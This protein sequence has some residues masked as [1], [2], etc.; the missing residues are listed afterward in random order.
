MY[1]YFV[2]PEDRRKTNIA[3]GEAQDSGSLI[4]GI[5]SGQ[6]I[7]VGR[8]QVNLKI[9]RSVHVLFVFVL[10]YNFQFLSALSGQLIQGKA[11][12]KRKCASLISMVTI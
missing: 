12:M 4:S 10:L 6:C 8:G 9:L 11:P 3:L 7:L 2:D 5:S 1:G